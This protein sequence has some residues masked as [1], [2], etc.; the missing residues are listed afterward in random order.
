MAVAVAVAVAVVVVLLLLLPPLPPLPPPPPRPR[1]RPLLLLLLLSIYILHIW[2]QAYAWRTLKLHQAART[3]MAVVKA[4]AEHGGKQRADVSRP[5]VFG[6]RVV[7]GFR[8][9]GV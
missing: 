5:G 4:V 8:G 2:M 3:A 6:S 1:P 9:L 7:A